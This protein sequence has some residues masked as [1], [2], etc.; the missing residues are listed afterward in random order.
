[1]QRHNINNKNGLRQCN[2]KSLFPE[3]KGVWVLLSSMDMNRKNRNKETELQEKGV[4]KDKPQT[5]ACT[6]NGPCDA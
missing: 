5:A 1:V 6:Q 4:R 2:P 3:S